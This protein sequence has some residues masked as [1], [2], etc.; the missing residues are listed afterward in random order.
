MS[1]CRDLGDG[2]RKNFRCLF[3]ERRL[4]RAQNLIMRMQG[5]GSSQS[6]CCL[7]TLATIAQCYDQRMGVGRDFGGEPNRRSQRRNRLLCS[8]ASNQRKR[9]RMVKLGAGRCSLEP[10]I[11]LGRAAGLVTAS[12]QQLAPIH[13]SGRKA[14]RGCIVA[15]PRYPADNY[16]RRVLTPFVR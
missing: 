16:K 1:T 12:A 7:A 5:A 10:F 8:S 2:Q 3:F 9:H 6:D 14:G 15:Y 11:E 4:E 13:V